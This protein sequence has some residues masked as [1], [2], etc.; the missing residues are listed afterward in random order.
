MNWEG[1]G[2][3]SKI[4]CDGKKAIKNT[5]KSC[6]YWYTVNGGEWTKTIIPIVAILRQL[7]DSQSSTALKPCDGSIK[8]KSSKR[9]KKHVSE[10]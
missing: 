8:S 4:S 2:S 7:F 1:H 9:K 5:Q 6:P 10:V 3:S